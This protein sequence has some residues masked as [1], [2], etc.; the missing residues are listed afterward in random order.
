MWV[1]WY[2]ASLPEGWSARETAGV[3]MDSHGSIT[4]Y[5]ITL[6]PA[7]HVQRTEEPNVLLFFVL[8]H[9]LFIYFNWRL[10]SLQYCG[11]FCHTF[12][13]VSHECTCIPHPE[14]P[15]PSHPSGSSQ[16]TSPECPVSCVEPGLVIYFTQGNIHGESQGREPG[17]LPSKGSHR[18]GHDWR[19][20]AA[21]AIYMFQC[22]SLKSSHSPTF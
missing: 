12:T 6:H 15:S 7:L 11:A 17:G 2:P 8:F 10:I 4:C 19:D 14:P 1:K 16:C 13:W 3:P 22:Y 18:V 9:F 20:L 21:A 5:M